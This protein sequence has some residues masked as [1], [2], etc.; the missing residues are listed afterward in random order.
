MC[1]VA[2]TKF[3]SSNEPVP[4]SALFGHMLALKP[5]DYTPT[6]T[7]SLTSESSDMAMEVDVKPSCSTRVVG[8]LEIPVSCLFW[9]DSGMIRFGRVDKVPLIPATS[10]SRTFNGNLSGVHCRWSHTSLR[11]HGVWV[12][13]R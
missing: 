1:E 10:H 8:K 2:S 9:L 11:W 3:H 12:S 7:A 6:E 4:I 5:F 13:R